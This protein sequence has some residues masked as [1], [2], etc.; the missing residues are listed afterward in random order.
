MPNE[1]D[2]PFASMIDET[3]VKNT[4][5]VE[6]P[7]ATKNKDG[8]ERDYIEKDAKFLFRLNSN[9]YKEIQMFAKI[10]GESVNTLLEE[11]LIQYLNNKENLEDYKKAKS[12]AEQFWLICEFWFLSYISQILY[13]HKAIIIW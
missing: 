9:F 2:N 1:K 4:D 3:G 13:L 11:A 12:I 6:A 5:V 7:R 8:K 10:R